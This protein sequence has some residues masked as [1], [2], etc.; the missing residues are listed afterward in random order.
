[1][2][3]LQLIDS[4]SGGY[5]VFKRNDYILD[6]GIYTELYCAMFSTTSSSWWADSAFGVQSEKIVSRT[7]NALKTYN[8]NNSESNLNLLKKAIENDLDRFTNKNP[9]IKIESVTIIQ[10]SN[11]ELE[12]VI[13]LTGYT[14]SFN[15]I[16]KKTSNS[17]DNLEGVSDILIIESFDE[18]FDNSFN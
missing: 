18:S 4:L 15:F 1:M 11:K 2:V 6:E 7:E 14:N 9:K 5:F 12:I 8:T 16:F 17:L 13:K 3:N 10:K